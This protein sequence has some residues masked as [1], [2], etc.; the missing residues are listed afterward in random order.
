MRLRILSVTAVGSL[1]A[2]M[3]IASPTIAGGPTAT[4]EETPV[5][6]E[7]PPAAAADWQGSYA[8]IAFAR[9]SGDNFWVVPSQGPSTTDDFSGN[10][11]SITG[12]HD[13]QRGNLVYG[14]GLTYGSGDITANPQT[15]LWTCDACSTTISK[16]ASLRGRI[17]LAMGKT[18]IYATGG[19]ALADAEGIIESTTLVGN[20]TLNGTVFGLGV[21]HRVGGNLS[22]SVE[23]LKTDLGRF[24]LA[25][26]CNVDSCYTDVE[27]DQ[28]QVGLNYR[29]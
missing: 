27:F 23:Y 3:S 16:M 22:V 19:I 5:V 26:L 9:P 14:L 18:L 1:L 29:W 21:E 10:V 15:N 20:D 13:W 11:T 2:V 24:D 25:E 8:G 7:M 12:G 17:G 28:M 6:A 4:T